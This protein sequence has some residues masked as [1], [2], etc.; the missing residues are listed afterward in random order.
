MVCCTKLSLGW[1]GKPGPGDGGQPLSGD[2]LT[3]E[4]TN[5]VAAVVDSL[6]RCFNLVKL[7]LLERDQAQSK[8]PVKGISGSVTEVCTEFRFSSA[9]RL[10]KAWMCARHCS[11]SRNSF[12]RCL[13]QPGAR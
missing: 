10:I 11:W 4:L 13:D 6:Q 2:L 9:A 5:T 7:L 8:V 1:L 12:S 3:S